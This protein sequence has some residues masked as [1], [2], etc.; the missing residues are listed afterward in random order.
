MSEYTKSEWFTDEENEPWRIYSQT[1]FLIADCGLSRR[2]SDDEM[3]A[4]SQLIAA[5]PDMLAALELYDRLMT[6]VWGSPNALS[7]D[8]G[9]ALQVWPAVRASILKAKGEA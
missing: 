1:G 4:N 6:E 7:D 3:S 2:L 8:Y 9:D 5:A